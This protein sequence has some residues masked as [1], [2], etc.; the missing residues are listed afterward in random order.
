MG[1]RLMKRGKLCVEGDILHIILQGC[2]YFQGVK[3]V[4]YYLIGSLLPMSIIFTL[5]MS[6]FHFRLHKVT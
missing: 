1:S 6:F 2:L 4:G 3:F 5:A